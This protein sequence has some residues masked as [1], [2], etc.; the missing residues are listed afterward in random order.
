MTTVIGIG[1]ILLAIWFVT[2]IFRIAALVQLAEEPPEE[3]WPGDVD[4]RE[5]VPRRPL[6]RSAAVAIE[7]PDEDIDTD[8]CAGR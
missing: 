6:S 7:E 1:L 3:V 8:A 2:R 5:P 4:V